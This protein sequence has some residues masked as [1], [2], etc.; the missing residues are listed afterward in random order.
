[1][2]WLRSIIAASFWPNSDLNRAIAVD[3][4]NATFYLFRAFIK[5]ELG[6]NEAAIIDLNQAISIDP[7]LADAYSNRGEIKLKLQQKQAALDDVNLAV[8]VAPRSGNAYVSRCRVRL[9]LKQTKEAINDCQRAVELDPKNP[10]GYLTLGFAKVESGDK[11]GG[12]ID[13]TKAAEIYRSMNVIDFYQSIMA[14]IQKLK[15]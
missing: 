15:E 7:K 9:V 13:L 8:A 4:K 5:S 3:P 11:P 6:Q 10:I 1:M 2:A 14:I 12:I